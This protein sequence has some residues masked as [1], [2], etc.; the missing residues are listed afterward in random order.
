MKKEVNR[1]N[2]HKIF[3]FPENSNVVFNYLYNSIS[4]KNK[5]LLLK[6]V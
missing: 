3:F 4:F 5:K 2:T 6:N 1:N